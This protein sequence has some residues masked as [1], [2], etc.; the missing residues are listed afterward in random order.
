[1]IF[2]NIWKVVCS[3][4]FSWHLCSKTSEDTGG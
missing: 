2:Q 4:N 3:D 1:V